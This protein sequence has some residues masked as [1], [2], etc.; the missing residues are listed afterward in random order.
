MEK[1]KVPLLAGNQ[2]PAFQPLAQSLNFKSNLLLLLLLLPMTLHP[3]VRLDLLS[4]LPLLVSRLR[5]K[6]PIS[7]SNPCDVLQILSEVVTIKQHVYEL[8]KGV[9]NCRIITT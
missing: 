9:K 3:P 1:R 8:W 7:T 4:D 5:I 6:S 2:T